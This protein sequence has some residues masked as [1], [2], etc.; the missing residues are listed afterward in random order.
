MLKRRVN[1]GG[2]F[3]CIGVTRVARVGAGGGRW[4]RHDREGSW[5]EVVRTILA[6]SSAA[7]LSISASSTACASLHQNE[8]GVWIGHEARTCV[9]AHA[10]KHQVGFR[11]AFGSKSPTTMTSLE[12]HATVWASCAA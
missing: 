5:A 3:K 6:S 2:E 9:R 8:S 4:R 11:K 7:R 10:F 1:R 12:A